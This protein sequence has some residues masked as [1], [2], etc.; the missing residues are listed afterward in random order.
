M[1]FF[2]ENILLC[3]CCNYRLI[4]FWKYFWYSNVWCSKLKINR[5]KS[6]FLLFFDDLKYN[7]FVLHENFDELRKFFQSFWRFWLVVIVTNSRKLEMIDVYRWKHQRNRMIE[8]NCVKFSLH[9]N[10]LFSQF[11]F[12][13]FSFFTFEFVF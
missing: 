13:I 6:L 3:F 1:W 2:N 9:R 5:S 10:D 12:E 8:I 4:N 11:C 7:E